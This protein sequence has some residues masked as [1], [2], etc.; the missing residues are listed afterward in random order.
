MPIYGNFNG[1][2]GVYSY[3]SENDRITITFN[4]GETYEYT[5][6]SSNQ[7]HIENMK[8]LAKQGRGLNAYINRHVKN[9]I[10]ENF[11]SKF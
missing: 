3:H 5:Y 6:H 4:S 10:Q 11:K 7:Y 2:S 9:F 8:N 1:D